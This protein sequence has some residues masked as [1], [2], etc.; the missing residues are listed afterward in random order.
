MSVRAAVNPELSVGLPVYNGEEFVGAAIEA[1]LE[2][3]FSDF[4][5]IIS[6]NASTDGTEAI[7][8][9]YAEQDQR[10]RYF[11]NDNNRG[12]AANWNVVF[13]RATAPYFKWIAHDD[14][15]EPEF[16]EKCLGV[17]RDDPSAVLAFTRAITIDHSGRFI[18]QW[19]AGPGL[20]SRSVVDRYRQGMAPAVDP[21]PLAIFGV[22]R[23][24]ALR[25]TRMFRWYPDAD[26]ALLAELSLR[27][28][29]HELAE[30]LFIQREHGNRAG[31][32]L[33]KN[34]HKAAS[35]WDPAK[36]GRVQFPHWALFSGH[37]AAL[38]KAPIG[39]RDRLSCL[40]VLGGWSR[41]HIG[42]LFGDIV[43]AASRIPGLGI[44]VRKLTDAV[45]LRN[46]RA[47][48][49][50]AA[51]DLKSLIPPPDTYVLVDAGELGDALKNQSNIGWAPPPDDETAVRELEGMRD[52]GAAFVVF[53]W[54]CFWWLTYYKGL[55]DHL[56]A[57]FRRIHSNRRIVVYD[58]R[59][60]SGKVN[61]N[62]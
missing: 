7:C 58:L 15:H 4:E 29:F 44:L 24:E 39:W 28:R 50:L 22:I 31:P 36:S 33:A 57:K 16:L 41:R 59:P 38:L 40:G 61:Q 25:A 62:S 12:A 3:T 37:L 17:L 32:Q 54:P 46:W 20:G 53:G 18:R 42:R 5:L 23:A 21:L 13:E 14:L 52:R 11:R 1:M 48:L 2:Q 10:V 47:R 56:E 30:P 60:E 8:R 45:R 26:I 34:P 43:I 35:F 51:R 6:D 27:G 19:G 9:R 49:K 55:V